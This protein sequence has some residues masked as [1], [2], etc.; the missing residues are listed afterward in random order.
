MPRPNRV[1]HAYELIGYTPVVRLNRIV[2]AGAATI[3]GSSANLLA[4]AQNL[5]QQAANGKIQAS[6]LQVSAA[7][8][9]IG[10]FATAAEYYS[11]QA[12]SMRGLEEEGGRIL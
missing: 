9:A 6:S 4:D 5:V 7:Q 10:A 8:A 2:P 11:T 3:Y 12:S 1:D